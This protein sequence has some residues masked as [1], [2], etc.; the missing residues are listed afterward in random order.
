[1]AKGEIADRAALHWTNVCHFVNLLNSRCMS[2]WSFYFFNL[3]CI[4]D[5]K[6]IVIDSSM[7]VDPTPTLIPGIYIVIHFV[8]V[9]F[10]LISWI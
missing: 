10:L 7:Y 3:L 2:L 1:M 6:T 8:I 9:G 5:T 4:I